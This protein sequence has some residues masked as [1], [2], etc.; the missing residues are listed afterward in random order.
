[1][2]L[3]R[4]RELESRPRTYN[5]VRASRRS[6]LATTALAGY[7]RSQARFMASKKTSPWLI[8]TAIIVPLLMAFVLPY[9]TDRGLANRADGIPA[10][11]RIARADDGSCI[12][13]VKHHHCYGLSFEVF[14]QGEAPFTSHLDVNVPD[15]WAS[16]IQPG[17]FVWIVRSHED[18]SQVS[19][20]VDA[21]AEPPPI[22]PR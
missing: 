15:R 7:G 18:K 14:P 20:A 17:S 3:K 1:M 8:A 12:V 21:F 22:D 5:T 4:L 10:V 11:A 13:G 19:L 2:S 16:R 6:N 9:I